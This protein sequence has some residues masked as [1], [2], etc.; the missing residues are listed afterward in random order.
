M[1]VQ[2]TIKPSTVRVLRHLDR[3]RSKEILPERHALLGEAIA[4]I[5]EEGRARDRQRQGQE[6]AQKLLD[7]KA[8]LEQRIEALTHELA[9]TKEKWYEKAREWRAATNE[10]DAARATCERLQAAIAKSILVVQK[11]VEILASSVPPG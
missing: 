4:I 2:G 11:G 1:D 3:L 7:E 10:R 8:A 5:R 9:A 6:R